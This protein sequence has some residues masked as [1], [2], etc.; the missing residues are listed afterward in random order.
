MTDS[1]LQMFGLFGGA[2]VI[3]FIAGMFPIVS[4]ELFLIGVSTWAHPSPSAIVALVLLGAVGHQIAKSV[5]YYAGEGMLALPKGKMKA[6]IEKA[7]ARIERWNKRPKLILFFAST[8]GFPPLY[9]MAFIVGPLMNI[10]FW[11]FTLFCFFGRIGR[12]ATLMMV[13]QIIQG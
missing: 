7:R 2:A 12:F 10:R 8:V 4:I 3:G 11:Q 13:P 1:L 9:L 5:C 6:R